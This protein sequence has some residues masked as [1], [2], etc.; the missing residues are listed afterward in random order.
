MSRRSSESEADLAR[1]ERRLDYHFGDRTLLLTALTHRSYVNES[2]QTVATNER[3][4]FLGD[5]VLA[6]L[7]AERLYRLYPDLSEG[8][9]TRARANMVNRGALAHAARALDLG[10]AIVLGR[11]TR[12]AGGH[13]L[14]SILADAYEAVVGAVYLDGGL[15]PARR[16]VEQTLSVDEAEL[17]GRSEGKDY[18]SRLQ[19]VVQARHKVAPQYL[20]IAGPPGQPGF[21]V[22]VRVDDTE[23]AEGAGL[24]KS[25]AEQ[26]A[27]REA[28]QLLGS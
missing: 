12:A 4:E 18:K 28:L 21:V 27:A 13:R 25:E 9:L 23:L 17:F 19:E 7:V 3:L 8:A 10:Q 14:D 20:L 1:L 24:S 26:A 16:L 6:F 11:G 5:A 15:E 2:Q 22:R